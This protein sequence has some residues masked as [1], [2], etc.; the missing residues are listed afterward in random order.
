[1]DTIAEIIKG[2]RNKKG[3][4]QERFALLLAIDQTMVSKLETGVAEPG[5]KLALKLALLTEQP[6]EMFIR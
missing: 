6:L 5:K 3:W 1:M 4:T 2:Y